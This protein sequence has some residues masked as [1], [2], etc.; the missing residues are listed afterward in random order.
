[1]KT[2]IIAEHHHQQLSP[3]TAHAIEAAKSFADQCDLVVIG[4]E[5]DTVIDDIKNLEHIQTCWVINQ[6]ELAHPLAEVQAPI[7][8]DMAKEYD[9]VMMASTTASKD[10]LPRIAGLMHIMPVTDVIEIV[11]KET[12]KRPIYAGNAIQTVRCTQKIKLISIRPTAFKPAL[13]E[14]K[15]PGISFKTRSVTCPQSKTTWVSMAE[16]SSE[17][18]EL[19]AAKIVVS[20]GRGLGS[21]ENFK[22]LE[23]L[24]DQ[25]GAAVG[26]SRAAVD[27]GFVPNDYQVGQ[28][29]KIIAPAVYLCFGISGAIQHLAGM[30]DSQTIIAINHDP[31]AP[32]FKVADFGYVGDLFAV[33]DRLQE[34]IT[35]TS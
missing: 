18:P 2:L 28:T 4:H 11:D 17:R 32:I 7:I 3:L 10:L 31:D 22:R 23:A 21:E 35:E 12:Y 25:I 6:P 8:A 20:G 34:N 33:I 15:A 13:A 5:L 16:A 19:T 14:K 1:M 29:G 27:A 26:A 24:A 30:K 9:V